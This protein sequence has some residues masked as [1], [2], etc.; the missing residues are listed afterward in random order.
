M[1]NR[2]STHLFLFHMISLP[3]LYFFYLFLS[4]QFLSFPH[5]FSL[6]VCLSIY[7]SLSLLSYTLSVS[8]SYTLCLDVLHTLYILVCLSLFFLLSISIWFPIVGHTLQV[9]LYTHHTCVKELFDSL[10]SL[11]CRLCSIHLV[12]SFYCWCVHYICSH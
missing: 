6:S 10:K 12:D 3:L 4:P 5:S 9:E 11:D 1:W 8:M 7:L 2:R